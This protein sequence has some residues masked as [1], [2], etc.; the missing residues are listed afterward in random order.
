M[1]TFVTR[2]RNSEAYFSQILVM[3]SRSSRVMEQ[4]LNS[5]LLFVVKW[6][7]LSGSHTHAH[8]CTHVG[9]WKIRR[10]AHSNGP[11]STFLQRHHI[12]T[13]SHPHVSYTAAYMRPPTCQNL[14]ST[15]V[16]TSSFLTAKAE[17]VRRLSC[18]FHIG[19]MWCVIHI[20]LYRKVLSFIW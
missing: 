19:I 15:L 13:L 6:L 14:F 20:F 11:A 2:E 4:I 18:N 16:A 8:A 17:A 10:T 1:P 7:F 5:C 12:I 3:W 9:E